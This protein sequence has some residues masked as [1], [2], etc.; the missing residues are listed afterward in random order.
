MFPA[1]DMANSIHS[2]GTG[3]RLSDKSN[4]A[5]FFK[6][7]VHLETL[8]QRKTFSRV[9]VGEMSVAEATVKV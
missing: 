2:V 1:S 7:R 6:L 3:R 8:L 4:C 5:S 9:V